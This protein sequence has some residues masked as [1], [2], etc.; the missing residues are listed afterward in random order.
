MFRYFCKIMISEK[1][2]K[3]KSQ[4]HKNANEVQNDNLDFRDWNS[5]QLIT[6]IYILGKKKKNIYI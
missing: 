1:K 4:K 2:K 6:L 5:R 3:T